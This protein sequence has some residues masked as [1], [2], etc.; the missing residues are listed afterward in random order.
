M[1]FDGGSFQWF[2]TV[3]LV[4]LLDHADDVLTFT[5]RSAG[6]KSRIPR[7]GCVFWLMTFKLARHHTRK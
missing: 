5:Q 2:E 6:R 3:A 1:V 4:H 7:A